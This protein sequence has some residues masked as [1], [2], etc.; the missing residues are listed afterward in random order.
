VSSHD[1]ASCTRALLS[2]ILP[3]ALVVLPV[4]ATE[5]HGPHLPTGT[6]ALIVSAVAGEAVRRAAGASARDLVLAPTVPFGASDHHFPFGGTL[7][8]RTETTTSVLLDLLRSVREAGGARVLLVNGHGGNRGP[9]HSAAH[10][11]STRYGLHVGY[12]DYWSLLA[13]DPDAARIP[14]HAGAFETSMVSHLRPGAVGPAPAPGPRPHRPGADDVVLHSEALWRA[15]DGYSDQPADASAQDGARWFE[16]CARALAA[17][18]T[19][20]AGSL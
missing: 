10:A 3:E 4:G 9:C 11:A 6:D 5:Q 13:G 15:I 19:D 1:W 2:D 14:G 16:A 12:L 8:L 17:R 20:L 7:S 18:I